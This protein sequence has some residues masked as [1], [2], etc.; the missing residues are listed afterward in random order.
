MSATVYAL[1]EGI[2]APS[3]EDVFTP[4]GRYD[5]EKDVAL[6]AGFLAGLRAWLAENG[7]TGKLAGK[8]V[9]WPRADGYARYMVASLRP[10]RLFH[11]P[12]GDAW[13]LDP[14]FLRGLTAADVKANVESAARMRELFSA[15]S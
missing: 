12:L 11:L 1:P 7:Y 6:E 9:R 4:E 13:N 10:L 3:F 8:E 5:R 15:K 14:I 2:E